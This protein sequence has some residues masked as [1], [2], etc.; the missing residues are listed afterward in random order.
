MKCVIK[1]KNNN[2]YFCKNIGYQNHWTPFQEAKMF[3]TVAK[4]K[5]VI[6]KYK[7]KNVEVIKCTK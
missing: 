3:E 7:L 1:Y 2:S 6:K 4:A 5:E